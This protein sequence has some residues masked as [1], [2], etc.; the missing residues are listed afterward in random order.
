MNFEKLVKMLAVRLVWN[1]GATLAEIA[2][3]TG[4]SQ[5]TIRRWLRTT[6]VKKVRRNE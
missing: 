5:S 3:A 4:K 1:N 2:K 6:G